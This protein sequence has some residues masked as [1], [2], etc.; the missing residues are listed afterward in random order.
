MVNK[1]KSIVKSEFENIYKSHKWGQEGAGSGSG[2][3][4]NYTISVRAILRQVIDEYSIESMLDAPCGSFHWMPLF[5]KNLTGDFKRRRGK[6]FRYHG[7]DAVEDLITAAKAKY[8][9]ESDWD[10]SVCDFSSEDLPN[11]Y[12]LIFSRD[13]LQHLPFDKVLLASVVIRTIYWN[14]LNNYLIFKVLDSLKAYSRVQGAKYLLVGSYLG[15]HGQNKYIRVG[16]YFRINLID[17]PFNL[18]KYIRIYDEYK[19]TYEPKSLI[20]YDIPN[21]LSKIDFDLIKARMGIQQLYINFF[22]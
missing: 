14:I 5:L 20:L 21:Y 10:F 13:A 4:I 2:S 8:S 11:G 19:T 15:I 17:N 6:Q 7:V 18:N 12:D 9:N 16:E 22:G 3:T 1:I